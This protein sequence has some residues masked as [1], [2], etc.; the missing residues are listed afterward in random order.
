M[1][2]KQLLSIITITK[3]DYS[4]VIS[5]INSTRNIRS[6]HPV[7]Q[8]IIDSSDENIAQKTKILCLENKIKYFWVKPEGISNAF[9]SGIKAT[10]SGWL[11]FLNAG[12]T[13]DSELN[14]DLFIS[15][16]SNLKAD[17]A[18]FQIYYSK[19]KRFN[20]IPPMWELWPV[21][22]NW[23]PHPGTLIKKDVFNKYGLF[24]ENF[25]IA[26]DGD[27]WLRVS[28]KKELVT[29]VISLPIAV[30][31]EDGV[32]STNLKKRNFE[33]RLATYRSILHAI[34]LFIYNLSKIL[35]PFLYLK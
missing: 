12:D 32:S 10:D 19:S 15:L 22:P 24:N 13:V 28:S 1:S 33:Q 18:I 5:T 25:K 3:N 17:I 23:I 7:Q 35:F 2:N 29:N 9:N 26:M 20:H 14:I 21:T 4:N 6:R 11:W 16:I 8:L 31:D 27:F 34:P 30:F